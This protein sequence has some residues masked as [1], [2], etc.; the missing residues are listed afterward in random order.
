LL[1]VALLGVVVASTAA[2]AGRELS[3]V[4]HSIAAAL[5]AV[6]PMDPLPP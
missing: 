6:T 5:A 1:F 2:V 3:G 4:L